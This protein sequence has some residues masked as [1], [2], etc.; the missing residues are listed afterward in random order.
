MLELFSQLL[1]DVAYAVHLFGVHDGHRRAFFPSSSRTSRT[2]RISLVVAGQSVV[3]HVCEVVDIE[4]SCC[5]V[6]S[7]EQLG[8]MCAKLLHGE[9]ALL[10]C[11]IAVQRFGVVSVAYELVGNLLCLCLCAAEDD[12][13][14]ARVVVD[15]A[16]QS[17]VFVGRS[18]KVL[19]VVYIFSPFVAAAHH[20][21]FGF[22]QVVL[23]YLL[24]LPAHGG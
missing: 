15:D 22:V 4:S 7:D 9:V 20:Y 3:Y 10:L 1:F 21:L 6:G 11:Q 13:I 23:R 17:E 24:H 16:F 2:V 5:H 8:D 19:E 12:G 14:D 18:D